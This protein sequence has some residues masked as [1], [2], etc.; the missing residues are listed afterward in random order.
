MTRQPLIADTTFI[1]SHSG[2]AGNSGLDSAHAWPSLQY[3]WNWINANVDCAGFLAKVVLEESD[4]EYTQSLTTLGGIGGGP[5]GYKSGVLFMGSY[6]HPERC[7]IHTAGN[8]IWNS[9][10]CDLQI[11]GIKL[12]SDNGIGSY[13]SAGANTWFNGGMEFAS[14]ID[15]WCQM[16]GRAILGMPKYKISGAKRTHML[17]TNGSVIENAVPLVDLAAGMTFGEGY[18]VATLNSTIFH[19]SA[20]FAS[21][22]ANGTRYVGA[23]GGRLTTNSG[24]PNYFP[25]SIPGWVDA[26]SSYS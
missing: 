24:N 9:G 16:Q 8:C 12:K 5:Q 13:T 25:G 14:P 6:D 1:V 26:Q 11:G 19:P 4:N 23:L 2:I 17:S 22:P 15:I 20:T 7:V 18:A 21:N 3:A 10:N